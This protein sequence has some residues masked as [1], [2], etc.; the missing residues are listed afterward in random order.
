MGSKPKVAVAL[1]GG[2]T[3]AAFSAGVLRGLLAPGLR[4]RF[5]LAA[6]SGTSGGAMGAALAWAGL[7][8]SGPEEARRRL[9]AFW[10]DLAASAPLDIALN[11]WL[12]LSTRLPQMLE[13]SPL[14]FEPIAEH[15]L[16][17][18]A[19]Q[20]VRLEAV[21]ADSP[22]PELILGAINVQSGER[23]LFN[24]RHLTYDRL[25][26]SAAVPPLFRA[27]RTD[28][29]IYWD[30]LFNIN[31]PVR[32]LMDLPA[33]PD[34]IWVVQVNPRRRRGE[35]KSVYD[36]IERLNELSGNLSLSQELYF[37]DRINRLRAA[38]ESLQRRYRHVTLR[39]LEFESD[40]EYPAKLDRSA[41]FIRDLLQQGEERAGHLLSDASRW[42]SAQSLALRAERPAAA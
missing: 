6:L 35:P 32:E 27:I 10:N 42:P 34:E 24:G 26:A 3:Y 12:V 14:L 13:A 31:P 23:V 28:S 15:R 9:A 21:P 8:E 7:R 33:P 41:V 18:L 25:L 2:G 20:Y 30:G 37:I 5:D 22:G 40:L 19:E 29:E 4:D 1:Q 11:S 17:S 36:I 39:L 38:H 16:R